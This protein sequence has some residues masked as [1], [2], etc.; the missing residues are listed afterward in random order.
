M[1]SSSLLGKYLYSAASEQPAARAI[2]LVVAR[3]SPTVSISSCAASRMRTRAGLCCAAGGCAP[4]C[5]MGPKDSTTGA[6]RS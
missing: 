2:S 4:V 1:N 3:A 5:C 6:S